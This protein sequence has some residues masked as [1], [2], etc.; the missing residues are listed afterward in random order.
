MQVDRGRASRS[1]GW[2]TTSAASA[3]PRP[4]AGIA[5]VIFG[6]AG[7][8]HV[9]VNPLTEVGGA[10]LGAGRRRPA[11]RSRRRGRRLG[12]TPSGEHG[13]G[14]LR[15]GLLRRIYGDEIVDLFARVKKA[16]DP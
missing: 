3:G 6:H 11:R 1:S 15:A 5:A 2:A 14:R 7:D 8:G 13:D 12:G 4:R 9:H 16:F 10:G